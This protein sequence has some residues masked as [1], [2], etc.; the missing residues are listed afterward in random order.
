MLHFD[1]QI[2][3]DTWIPGLYRRLCFWFFVGRELRLCGRKLTLLDQDFAEFDA[4]LVVDVEQGD[5][6]ATDGR[7]ADQ[8]RPF[9]AEMPRPFVAAGVEQ[10][11]DLAGLLVE[12]GQV[13]TLERITIITT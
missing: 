2:S 13:G 4:V 5:G 1:A 10:R 3:P 8:V 11:R 9:P 6:D 12:A 7:A